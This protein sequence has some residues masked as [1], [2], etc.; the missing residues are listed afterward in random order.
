MNEINYVNV[1]AKIDFS[2]IV[3]GVFES[4]ICKN[5]LLLLLLS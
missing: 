5:D 4:G 3:Q 1:N 2:Q